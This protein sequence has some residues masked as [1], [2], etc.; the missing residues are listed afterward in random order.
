MTPSYLYVKGSTFQRDHSTRANK[1]AVNVVFH[2]S[3]LNGH[4]AVLHCRLFFALSSEVIV[5]TT[6]EVQKMMSTDLK[7]KMDVKMKLDFVCIPEDEDMGTADA[8]RHIQ[9]KIKV[10]RMQTLKQLFSYV[11]YSDLRYVWYYT[12]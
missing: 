2:L 6:K 7:L 11:C 10:S 5:I 4:Y 8:L 3:F 9:P 1:V 12:L